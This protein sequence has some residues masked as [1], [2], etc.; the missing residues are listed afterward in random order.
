MNAAISNTFDDYEE[1]AM[2]TAKTFTDG[3]FFN[4][5]EMDLLHAALGAGS[6]AG[7]LVDAVKKHLIYGK[8]LDV[9]NVIEEIG[10]VM[11]FLSLA[12]RAIG[13]DLDSCCQHNIVKLAKRYPEKYS[14]ELAAMRLDKNENSAG[15][16]E[17]TSE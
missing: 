4:A 8:P 13:V 12:C 15:E 1:C 7:E 5:E 11:W 14:D 9:D 3:K 2:R 16:G 6:D 17:G 10:D